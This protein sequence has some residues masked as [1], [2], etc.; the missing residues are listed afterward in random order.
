MSAPPI[1]LININSAIWIA[2]W[3]ALQQLKTKDKTHD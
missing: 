1:N 3:I 2:I